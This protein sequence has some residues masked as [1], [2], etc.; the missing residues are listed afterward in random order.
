[1]THDLLPKPWLSNILLVDGFIKQK[2][3]ELALLQ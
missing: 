1:M 3:S 2:E